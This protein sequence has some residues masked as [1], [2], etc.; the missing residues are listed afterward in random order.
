MAK[1]PTR[2][3]TKKKP[4]AWSKVRVAKARKVS[5]QQVLADATKR[6]RGGRIGSKQYKK[7]KAKPYRRNTAVVREKVNLSPD[8][9]QQQVNRWKSRSKK[10]GPKASIGIRFRAGKETR[11]LGTRNIE[12]GEDIGILL[13][14][15]Y[16]AIERYRVKATDIV[17]AELQLVMDAKYYKRNGGKKRATSRKKRRKNK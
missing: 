3:P 9:L 16:R 11:S 14:D 10:L 4:I 1:R 15:L 6:N 7:T 8:A 5:I 2:K 13:E 12:A 17:S